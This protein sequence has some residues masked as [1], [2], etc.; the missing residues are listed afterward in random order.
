[1]QS[2]EREEARQPK[3]ENGLWKTGQCVARD[4]PVFVSRVST[5]ADRPD[6]RAFALRYQQDLSRRLPSLQ[7]PMSLAGIPKG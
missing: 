1:M 2:A 3:T 7:Q 5:C 4:W 6:E